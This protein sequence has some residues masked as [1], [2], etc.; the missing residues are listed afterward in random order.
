MKR[1]FIVSPLHVKTYLNLDDPRDPQNANI[2]LSFEE[3]PLFTGNAGFTGHVSTDGILNC[4]QLPPASFQ[5]DFNEIKVPG[6]YHYE[7]V[8]Y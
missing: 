1:I 8:V 3:D 2:E 6:P 5:Y 7:A 4:P